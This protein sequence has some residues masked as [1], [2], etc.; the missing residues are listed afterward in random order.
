MV[1]TDEKV[2]ELI[3]NSY[4]MHIKFSKTKFEKKDYRMILFEELII[5]MPMGVKSKEYKKTFHR[6]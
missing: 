3:F 1:K 6:I 5:N 4:N 2:Q